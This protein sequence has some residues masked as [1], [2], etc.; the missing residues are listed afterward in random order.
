MRLNIQKGI[1]EVN[2]YKMLLFGKIFM[3]VKKIYNYFMNG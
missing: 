3:A 1:N 2:K